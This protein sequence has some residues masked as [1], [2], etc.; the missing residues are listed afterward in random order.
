MA[1][2]VR[3]AVDLR[4]RSKTPCVKPW[5][6]KCVNSSSSSPSFP[7]PICLHSVALELFREAF[8]ISD[9]PLAFP[10]RSGILPIESHR[11]TKAMGRSCKALGLAAAGPHDLR[12]TGRTALTSERLGVSYEA[13]E[14]VIAHLVGSAVSR[15]YDRN[16]YL[17][18]KRGA[19]D[20]WAGEV[21]AIVS[22]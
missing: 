19:L 2:E 6:H 8:A 13:A 18:E 20:A 7:K 4:S 3:Q 5:P 17:R 10:D 14:R 16:E 9:G 12:R 1:E 15:V 21:A 22:S 11:L